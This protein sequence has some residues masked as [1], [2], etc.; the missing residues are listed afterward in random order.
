MVQRDADPV[1][2]EREDQ[3]DLEAVFAAAGA[4]PWR[5]RQLFRVRRVIDAIADVNRLAVDESPGQ[6]LAAKDTRFEIG[7]GVIDVVLGGDPFSLLLLGSPSRG[8]GASSLPLA[9]GVSTQAV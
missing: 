7:L 1:V 8:C 3:D 9:A 6:L 4:Q 2:Q 5:Q